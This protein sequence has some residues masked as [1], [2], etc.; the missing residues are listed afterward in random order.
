MAKRERLEVIHDILM[1]IKDNARPIKKTPLLRKS[2]L[3]SY[4]FQEYFEQLI[5]DQFIETTNI[6]KESFIQLT[7]KGNK[8]LEKYKGILNFIE[9][10]GL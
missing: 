4:R 1:I 7:N 10:F 9:E 8:Y 2:N 5:N 3:S 6:K